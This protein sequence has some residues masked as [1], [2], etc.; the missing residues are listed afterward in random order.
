MHWYTAHGLCFASEL[1]FP[2]LPS[3]SRREADVTICFGQVDALRDCC[4]A[5]RRGKQ[6]L[7][8]ARRRLHLSRGRMLVALCAADVRSSSSR[9][10]GVD[11]T[12]LSALI[13]DFIG[14]PPPSARAICVAR[15]RPPGWRGCSRVYGEVRLGKSTLA[16][17]L[18]LRGCPVISDDIISVDLAGDFPR[19]ISSLSGLNVWPETLTALVERSEQFRTC[20]TGI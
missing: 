5:D 2:N 10:A 13:L 4:P 11:H 12:T 8:N 18:Y 19:V 1:A 14:T 9:R 7:H 17:T 6:L 20:A 3:C 16:L 15:K